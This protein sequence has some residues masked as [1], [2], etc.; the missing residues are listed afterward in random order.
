[1]YFIRKYK[2]RMVVA[3]VAII[4]IVI[5]GYTGRERL[6]ISET[7]NLVGRILTPFSDI[8]A[9]IHEKIGS[10]FSSI[11]DIFDAKEENELLEA[12]LLQLESENRDLKNVIGKEDY[13]KKEQMISQTTNYELLKAE[14]IAKEPGNWFDQFIIDKGEEDGILKGATVVQGIELERD[15]YI[16]SLVGRVVDVGDN[17][18]KVISVVDELNSTSF[19]II[20]TQDGGVI[21]GNIDSSLEGYLFDYTADI[22][23][24]DELYT[25][26]LGGIYLK[27]IYIGEVIEIISD[28]EE[29]TK[30]LVVKPSINFKKL[31]NVF[32]ILE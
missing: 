19:K 13:L 15:V 11:G 20:R 29:L 8:S 22:I 18:S 16:E 7:E 12:R 25:S 4:L 30:R 28:E 1:M 3:L 24:G 2:E 31:Y 26:G 10:V 23:E 6:K 14:V 5:I 9:G 32:V 17:W 21:T 27:D